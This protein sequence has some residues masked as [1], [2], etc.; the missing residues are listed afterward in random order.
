MVNNIN[1]QP[2]INLTLIKSNAFNTPVLASFII[3]MVPPVYIKRILG[4]I[5][6]YILKIQ[7]KVEKAREYLLQIEE[8]HKN[9][10]N[11]KSK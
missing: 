4:C 8:T 9:F 5:I 1:L 10:N 3:P 7:Y 11:G 6:N 2:S